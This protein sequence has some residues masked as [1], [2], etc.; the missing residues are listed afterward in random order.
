MQGYLKELQSP[1]AKWLL[2]VLSKLHHS[3]LQE[4]MW[5]LF[6][7]RIDPDNLIPSVYMRKKKQIFKHLS[8]ICMGSWLFKKDQRKC[9]LLSTEIYLYQN[10][11]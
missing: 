6:W 3:N 11:L 7:V 2:Q 4:D 9:I 10:W 5:R 1:K 8:K